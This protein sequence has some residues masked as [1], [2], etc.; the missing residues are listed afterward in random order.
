MPVLDV[1]RALSIKNPPL[2]AGVSISQRRG[3]PQEESGPITY[4]ITVI[5]K[6]N[7]KL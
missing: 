1:Y 4:F 6:T 7:E 2:G 5:E 3:A